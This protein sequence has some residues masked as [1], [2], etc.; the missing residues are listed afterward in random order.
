[1]TRDELVE[2][3]A[4]RLIE[5]DDGAADDSGLGRRW[6]DIGGADVHEGDCTQVSSTCRYCLR[7][8]YFARAE[9]ILAALSRAGLAVVPLEATDEMEE[10]AAEAIFQDG[11]PWVDEERDGERRTIDGD[12]NLF[13]AYRAM[14][15]A[16]AVEMEE[17][18]VDG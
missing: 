12:A 14:V 10:A 8:E 5:H 15:A 9:A 6:L 18:V 13:A 2:M 4:V 17:I 11:H 16:G 1:M 7:L 3:M